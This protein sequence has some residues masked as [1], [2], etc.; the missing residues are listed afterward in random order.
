MSAVASD[1]RKNAHNDSSIIW[2]KPNQPNKE[3]RQSQTLRSLHSQTLLGRARSSNAV[4]AV[5]NKNN[6]QT[7]SMANLPRGRDVA[8][9]TQKNYINCCITRCIQPVLVASAVAGLILVFCKNL[10]ADN[11]AS[12][13]VP[14]IV[15][16]CLL[17][18]LSLTACIGSKYYRKDALHHQKN[19]E[20]Q[21]IQHS[22]VEKFVTSNPTYSSVYNVSDTSI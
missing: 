6:A 16:G 12:K 13:N 7:T 18:V 19:D 22:V 11:D 8:S 2:L 4:T 21:Q 9:I 14:W 15:G 10:F 5:F 3:R 17:F 20:S 1:S